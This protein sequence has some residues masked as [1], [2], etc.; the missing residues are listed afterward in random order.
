MAPSWWK[1]SECG[2][3]VDGRITIPEHFKEH[4]ASPAAKSVRQEESTAVRPG[5]PPPET[6][7]IAVRTEFTHLEFCHR[8][9]GGPGENDFVEWR[10]KVTVRGPVTVTDRQYLVGTVER[11]IAS[12]FR[13]ALSTAVRL[14][15]VLG[16]A[17]P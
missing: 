11:F 9:V 8:I 4:H 14:G 12:D 15:T 13:L 7:P 10:E 5:N 2:M 16:K 3:V 1:C 17:K 6:P